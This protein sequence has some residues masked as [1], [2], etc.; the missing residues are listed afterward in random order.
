MGEQLRRRQELYRG[1]PGA[2]EKPG[3][4]PC[5]RRRP[6]HAAL[7]RPP[8]D[9]PAE[10]GEASPDQH[11]RKTGEYGTGIN[12][13]ERDETPPLDGPAGPPEKERNPCGDC[14]HRAL[15]GPDGEQTA[16]GVLHP[17]LL[18]TIPG[19]EFI[20]PEP[21]KSPLD[22]LKVGSG[23]AEIPIA[24]SKALDRIER[25]AAWATPPLAIL[26]ARE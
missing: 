13:C 9:R 14:D 7:R 6:R 20:I 8:A 19:P 18:I 1:D 15:P 21:T 5:E 26:E 25:A 12:Q 3:D 10:G 23:A 11:R 17:E 16:E 4:H 24:V 2:E 22:D